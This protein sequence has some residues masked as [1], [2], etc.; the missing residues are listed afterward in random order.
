[1]RFAVIF[2]F[3]LTSVACGPTYVDE[4]EPGSIKQHLIDPSGPDLGIDSQ[5]LA[6][7][8]RVVTNGTVTQAEVDEGCAAARTGRTLVRF[9]VKTPNF[10]PGDLFFG[11]VE[12]F[13]TDATAACSGVSCDENPAC[14]C[15]GRNTCVASGGDFGGAFEFS[16]PHGHIH[17]KSFA[18]Y[19]LLAADGTVAA[20]GHKQSFC[21]MDI[22]GATGGT[23]ARANRFTCGNQGIH[24]GCADVYSSV[25]PCSFVDATGVPPGD[26]T[27]EVTM[28]PLDVI[29]ESNEGN[30]VGRTSVRIGNAPP[31]TPVPTA[32]LYLV[33][34]GIGTAAEADAYYA[35]LEP[36]PFTPG[37]TT[38]DQWRDQFIAPF[39]QATALYR[40]KNE[41]GFWRQ[42]TC[43][44][45]IDRSGG[46]C[47]VTNWAQPDDPGSGDPD[48][49][50]VAMRL[51]AE[52]RTQFFV[53][54]PDGRLSPSAVLDDEGAKFVPRLCTNCHG[55][56]YQG[57]GSDPDLGSVFREFEPSQ[58]QRRPGITAAQA[59]AEWFALNQAIRGANQA[60]RSEAE[61]GPFGVDFVKSSMAGYLDDMYLA[62]SPPVS[63]D[64]EDP[65]HVPAS[66]QTGETAA[67]R[68]KRADVWTRVVNPYC[69]TCHRLSVF[70][71]ESYPTFSTLAGITNGRPLLRRYIEVNSAD[72]NRASFPFMPQSK[73]QWQNLNND[74]EALLAIDEWLEEAT[75]RAPTAAAGTDR[76]APVGSLVALS[77]QGSSDP[78]GDPLTFTWEVTS[79]PAVTFA[80]SSTGRDVTFVAPAVA[81]NTDLVIRLTARDSR[82]ASATDTVVVTLAPTGDR[83]IASATDT[84]RSIP[85]NDT[86]GAASAITVSDSRL[87]SELRVT[88]DIAHTWIGDLRVEL[89]GPDGLSKVLH[90]RTGSGTDDIRQTYFVPEAVGRATAGTWQLRVK[91]LANLDTGTLRAWSIDFGTS[92]LPSNRPPVASAGADRTVVTGSQVMVSA[93]GSSDPDG[94]TLSYVWS[95][96]SGPAVGFAPS[97]TARDVTI[98]APPVSVNTDVSLRLRVTDGAGAQAEDILVITVTP[99]DAGGRIEVASTDTPLAITDGNPTGVTSSIAV[100]QDH[101]IA[102]MTAIVDITHTWRGDLRVVLR[103]PGGFERVLHDRSGG[104]ADDLNQAFVISGV[105]GMRSGGVWQLVVSD[106]EAADT[107][108]LR[109]WTIE[110]THGGAPPPPADELVRSATDTPLSIP[111]NNSTG[112]T[113][114]IAVTDAGTVATLHVTVAID[115]TWS[116]DL[117][118]TLVGPGGFTRVLRDRIG[119]DAD[120]IRTTFSVPDAAGRGA[121]GTWQLKVTDTAG[122]D[123]GVLETWSL[124]ISL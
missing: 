102:E 56:E 73:L 115:H 119:G 47:M 28:D 17:F 90:N 14:C 67:I 71:Y 7:S 110:M 84:P 101:V 23:C 26:Y 65:A 52:G 79:G 91:D 18:E 25:L 108:V 37:V 69:M 63:R 16:C 31:P 81:G 51:D 21:L 13:S 104:S 85:D 48:L 77:A 46:A 109:G 78:D 38:L 29:N 41:L 32:A 24:A 100:T 87:I 123:V 30:N 42:M 112:V 75:N 49:G 82:F 61:G 106:H 118:L 11:S 80:P 22:E 36:G 98:L 6:E 62:T 105:T 50:T 2:V 3:A 94:D 95:Q 122:A 99:P 92:A 117:K 121:A 83:V 96:I 113:S 45:T 33:R 9:D 27:L 97:A 4:K 120:D 103:G 86:T 124:R 40:N 74:A 53:F 88:V 116:G 54:T 72:P 59:E 111:D 44:T 55:G 89:S 39:P 114:S 15:N 43:T 60:V 64:V 93:A 107:G 10:G 20:N 66:W 5:R 57:I 1:M 76:I 8:A 58:L 70:N 34:D 12:C 19:R 35:A 68:Q